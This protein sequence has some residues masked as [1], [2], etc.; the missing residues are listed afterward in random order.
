MILKFEP[1]AKLAERYARLLQGSRLKVRR[2]ELGMTQ[3][4]LADLTGIDAKLI[5]AYEHDRIQP[6]MQNR[7]ILL[8][9][10]DG[11]WPEEA[12]LWV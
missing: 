6:R 10:L 3:K 2:K 7:R 8:E 4:Q 12:C 1:S 5:S 11:I 9:A